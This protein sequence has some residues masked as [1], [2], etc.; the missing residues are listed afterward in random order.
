MAGLACVLLFL[1]LAFGLTLSLTI[2]M[3]AP[4]AL[5]KLGE[6]YRYIYGEDNG[7]LVRMSTNSTRLN[8]F[9]LRLLAFFAALG[10]VLGLVGLLFI[11]LQ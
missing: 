10:C 3:Q 6:V 9:T 7:R 5:F 11:L 4:A 2:M 1:A 8:V